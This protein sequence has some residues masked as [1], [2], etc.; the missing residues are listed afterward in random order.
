MLFLKNPN[1]VSKTL[2][3]V[4]IIIAILLFVI[5][6]FAGSESRIIH[7]TGKIYLAIALPLLMLCPLIG[8]FSSFFIKGKVKILFILA[9]FICLCTLSIFAFFSFMFRYFVPFA[10]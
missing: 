3:I 8:L 7:Y 2:F 6:H 4:T 5:L 10:P 1:K 9:H